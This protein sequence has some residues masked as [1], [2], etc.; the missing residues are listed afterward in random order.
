MKNLINLINDINH[1]ELHINNIK[2]NNYDIAVEK[3]FKKDND[4][5]VNKIVFEQYDSAKFLDWYRVSNQHVKE[6]WSA[7]NYSLENCF[8]FFLDL[9]K[10]LTEEKGLTEEQITNKLDLITFNKKGITFQYSY[11]DN[12]ETINFYLEGQ[13]SLGLDWERIKN[14]ESILNLI[15]WLIRGY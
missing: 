6:G 1:Y 11:Y 3:H 12:W 15:N 9:I 7:Q 5:I 8:K 14:S 13:T 10:K 2:F 4:L